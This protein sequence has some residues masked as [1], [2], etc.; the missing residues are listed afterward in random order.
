MLLIV[1]PNRS[2]AMTAATSDN[3]KREQRNDRRA[4]VHQEHHDDEDDEDRAF[5]EAVN[6]LCERLLDEVRLSEQIPWICMPL[7]QGALDIVERRVDAL[8]QFQRVDGWLFLNADDDGRFGIVRAFAPL[9][10]RAFTN[11]SDVADQYWRCIRGL[12]ADGGDRVDVTETA[13]AAHEVLLPLCDLKS[14]GRVLVRGGQRL[15]NF[16]ERDLVAARRAGSSTTSYCFCSPP[17]AITCETPGTARRRRR[18]T[19]SAAVRSSSGECRS[20]SRSMNSTSPMIEET[21]ARNGGS[22]F[23]GNEPDTSVSFSVTV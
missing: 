11:D 10:R 9:D 18:T 1:R 7:R 17:V 6:R 23:G 14:C 13:D 12:D 4:H 15:F 21:G 19:V 22:T 16:L 8:G 5:D 20:D 2:I 3:G